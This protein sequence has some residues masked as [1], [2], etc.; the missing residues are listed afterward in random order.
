M[1]TIVTLDEATHIY[2]DNYGKTYL[3]VSAFLG[4]FSKKFDRE[5]KMN[6]INISLNIKTIF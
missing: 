2:T 1:N 4:L 5:G 6:E 3:S